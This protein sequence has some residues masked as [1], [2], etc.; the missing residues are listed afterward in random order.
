MTSLFKASHDFLTP[1]NRSQFA[2]RVR[3][4][5]DETFSVTRFTGRE[6]ALSEDYR[7][8]ITLVSEGQIPPSLVVGRQGVLELSRGQHPVF[9]HGVVG[10]CRLAG[11]SAAGQEYVVGLASPLYPLKLNR[12]NR[13]F[14]NQ[15][16]PQIVE[17]VLLGA[18]LAAG[19][20]AFR[21]QG[22]YPV[23]EFTVQ[24]EESDYD[25][26]SR[27]LA[28]HGLFFRF[29]S[30]P[31][32]S[33]VVFHDALDA[34]P[35]VP[36][37]GQLLFQAHSGTNRTLETIFA[38]RP[39]AR[40][41]ADK[42]Q[43]NDH[44][45]R[46]PEVALEAFGTRRS[47]VRGQGCDYRYGE[48]H[49][50]LPEVEVAA[51]IRQQGLDWQRLTFI[52]ESD[53]RALAP[54]HRL[55]LVQHPEA[56]L[57]GEY[58]VVEVEPEGDQGAGLAMGG[59]SGGMTYRNKM[60]LIRAGIPFRKPVSPPRRVHGLFTARVE[61]SG[62][63]YACLDDQGRYRVRLD[64]D[65]GDANP[66]EASQ[67]VRMM[68]PYG[69]N[70]FGL[71]FP[72]QAGAEVALTCING[73]LDRPILLGA[74]AN[75][76]T[77]NPV[78]AANPSQHILR[79]RGGN[80]L[81]MED[82]QG[83]EKSELFTRD[84]KNLL[85][86]DADAGGHLVTLATAEGEMAISAGRTLLIESGKTQ[87]LES[88]SDHRVSVANR[89]QLVT[90]TQGIQLQAAT[91]LRLAAGAHLLV[92]AERQDVSLSAGRNLVAEAGGSLSIEV[93]SRDLDMLVNQGQLGIEVARAVTLKG[94]GGGRLHIGQ[95]DGAIE[96]SPAGDLALSG[97]AVTITAARINIRGGSVG[98]N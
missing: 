8:E 90:K 41:L 86:L 69:G 28:H 18:G 47:S 20:F 44:N 37:G 23:R 77:P 19:D 98:N 48:N 65:Q 38:F 93:L 85:S 36:G 24:Y 30:G 84:R 92:Q 10:D 94:Q 27:F 35:P 32:K 5:P 96:V 33:R 60:L 12:H 76:E 59:R 13:V 63:A 75:P 7:Y 89:Q 6:H 17:E 73:D 25:F 78:T 64:F 95:G 29:D 53:C 46:T 72:L 31:E 79:T 14:I 40:L 3:G 51:R 26:L 91:D 74:L 87:T 50:S 45:Y 15:S 54:G 1:A 2:F 21:L 4:V 11:E 97:P 58:L 43:L 80:E 83:K 57:N 82:R 39:R 88:G 56:A 67:P 34:L 66:G 55:T 16:V 9:V 70:R 49:K 71:H 61:S 42:V 52:A 68:Q 81:L 62:G 22:G